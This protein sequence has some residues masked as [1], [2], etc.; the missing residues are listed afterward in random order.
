MRLVTTLLLILG[1]PTAALAEAPA[2]AAPTVTEEGAKAPTADTTPL[3]VLTR[4]DRDRICMVNN[5][6][7]DRP[8]IPVDYQGR[9][10]YGCC[11]MCEEMLTQDA[12]HRTA[13]DPVTRKPVD[14]ATALVAATADRRVLYFESER[15]FEELR[16]FLEASARTAPSPGARATN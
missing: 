12:R 1:L 15:S 10:Y 2:A 9:T 7:F 13:L 4:V 16:T 5:K 8:M 14:K 3:G 6:L 11:S